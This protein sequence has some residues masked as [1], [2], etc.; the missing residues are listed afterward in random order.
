MEREEIG[1]HHFPDQ[2]YAP[3]GRIISEYFFLQDLTR[4]V[5]VFLRHAFYNIRCACCRVQRKCLLI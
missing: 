3:A 1:L 2:S 5:V 4:V